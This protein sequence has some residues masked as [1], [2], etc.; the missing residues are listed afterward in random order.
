MRET[1]TTLDIRAICG[2]CGKP[3]MDC[4]CGTTGGNEWISPHLKDKTGMI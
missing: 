1:T 4:V 2:Y 3:L